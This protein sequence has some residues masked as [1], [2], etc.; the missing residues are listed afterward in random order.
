M[1]KV[2]EICNDLGDNRQAG[3]A[4]SFM[5]SN[6]LIEGNLPVTD[7]YNARLLENALHR[8]NPVQ[9]V[10]NLQWAGSVAI[11]RG[12]FGHALEIADRARKVMER[13][14]VGEVAEIVIAGIRAEASWHMGEQEVA[15]GFA[16]E[17][18]DRVAKIQVVDYSILVGFSHAMDVIFLALQ[19]A[20]EQDHP[21]AEKNEL[22]YYARLAI[23]VMKAYARVFTVGEP[24]VYRYTGWIE[25]HSGKREKAFRAWRTAAE[26]AH[27]IP[28]HYE[29]G[30]SYLLLARHLSSEDRERNAYLDK[31][32]DAFNRGSLDHWVEI[33]NE[34]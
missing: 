29:E 20:D 9:I 16:K 10:W 14:P 24:A 12:E 18:L 6:A 4:L 34:L 19:Q 25:W 8:N 30:S 2:V 17:L 27:L 13:T 33:T 3:E 11:R 28:M 15:I 21:Q 22:I 26:K 32:R 5:A 23:K 7:E 1:E 31:A